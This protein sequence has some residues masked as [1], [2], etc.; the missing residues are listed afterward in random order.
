M[1]GEGPSGHVGGRGGSV[2]GEG[3][4]GHVG[5][6]GGSVRGEGPS[7]H[8]GGGR[9][10]QVMWEGGVGG[11]RWPSNSRSLLLLKSMC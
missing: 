5:G 8:V 9:V 11:G 2:R 7:G 4:S 1:R 3:P 10:P 6:R